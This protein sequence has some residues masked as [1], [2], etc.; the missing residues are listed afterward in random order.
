MLLNMSGVKAHTL[1]E[2]LREVTGSI[3]VRSTMITIEQVKEA[4]AKF[5]KEYYNYPPI[6]SVGITWD[7]DYAVCVNC[8][9]YIPNDLPQEIDGVKVIYRVRNC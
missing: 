7:K 6:N 9:D 1:Q 4:N 5:V 2:D 3:P 8:I